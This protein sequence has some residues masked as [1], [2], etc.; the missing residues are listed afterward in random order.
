MLSRGPG[1]YSSDSLAAR[2]AIIPTDAAPSKSM[3]ATRLLTILT[4]YAAIEFLAVACSAYI[5]AYIYQHF[6]LQ[7][8]H[9]NTAYVLAAIAIA[10]LVL[11][12]SLGLH[13]FIEIRRQPRHI[14]LW[15]GVGSA[16]LAFSFFITILFFT[17][18]ANIYS[19]VTFIFQV[20]AV[21]IAVV[22]TRI[23]LFSWLQSAIASNRIEARRV[24][25]IGAVSDCATFADRLKASGIRIIGSLRLPKCPTM[26][27]ATGT[28]P[29]TFKITN[30]IR[31]LRADDIVV[32][33]DNQN[34]P[35]MF[36]LT[37][38]LAELPA[39]IHIFP[40][41][42]LK[43]L[44]TAEIIEFGNLKTIQVYRPPLATFDLF[45]KRTFD[46]ISA[47]I[48]LIVLSPLFL[49]VSIAI[50]LDS[51]GPV[52]FRQKRHG[53]NNEEI[54]VFKFRSMTTM[55]DGGQF[56]QATENDPRVTRVGR[57]IR[58][59][60]IDELPQLINVLRGEMSI[61]GPRPHATAHNALF[62]NMIGRFSRRHNV[63]PG[64]T[65]WAQVN[66]FRGVTD[67]LEKMQ[68]R[69]EYDLH[70]VDNWSFL[71]D[72]KIIVTTLFS[73]RAYTNTY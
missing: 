52:F 37:S 9:T 65:G 31:P 39:G 4:I 26:K 29:N 56:T 35:A 47:I 7:S 10:T 16:W 68:R 11:L 1:L 73:K 53:F 62:N 48:G 8:S 33:T 18:H 14:F 23:L 19:R 46:L 24:V 21:C 58:S 5:S 66:G 72:V 6:V 25:L 27:G 64:I 44:A 36:C 63:K 2:S 42:A 59:T 30:E 12:T 20:I 67:T 45:I 34:M 43:S 38:S 40:V 13:N 57:V 22:S 41:D 71:F 61:V 54:R 55:E 70:Y 51:P 69:I 60:N 49:I 32:L 28:N 17:Q 3:G 50:K 15:R